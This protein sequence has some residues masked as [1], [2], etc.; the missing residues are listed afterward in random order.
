MLPADLGGLQSEKI[1]YIESAKAG[2]E[3]KANITGDD[4]D[5]TRHDERSVLVFADGHVLP[6]S[7]GQTAQLVGVIR[8]SG[9]KEPESPP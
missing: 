9:E 6:Y 1:L 8:P 2:V 7:E 5:Y 4:I 3:P